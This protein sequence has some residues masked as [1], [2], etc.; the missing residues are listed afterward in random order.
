MAGFGVPEIAVY[1]K[2]AGNILSARRWQ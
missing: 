2:I 1:Y